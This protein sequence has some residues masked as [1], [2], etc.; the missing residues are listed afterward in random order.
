MAAYVISMHEID[1]HAEDDNRFYMPIDLIHHVED[2]INSGKMQ[3]SRMLIIALSD[4]NDISVYSSNLSSL[5]SIG[6]LSIAQHSI[7]QNSAVDLD[8]E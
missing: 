4:E 7:M 1:P 8:E 5:E 6:V 3:T 2:R